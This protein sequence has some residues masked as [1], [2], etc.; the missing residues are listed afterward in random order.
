MRTSSIRCTS[1]ARLLAFG[2]GL[3]CQTGLGV[4]AGHHAAADIPMA[5]NEQAVAVAAGQYSG[6]V[7]TKSGKA[8]VWGSNKR[9]GLAAG[10]SISTVDQLR[11]FACGNVGSNKTETLQQ[12]HLGHEHS[13]AITPGGALFM[14]GSAGEGQLGLGGAMGREGSYHG[15]QQ[16][17]AVHTPRLIEEPFGELSE[18]VCAVGLSRFFSLFLCRSGRLYASGSDFQF[19]MGVGPPYCTSPCLV[20]G[21]PDH[22][23]DPVVRIAAGLSFSLAITA[24]GRVF[25]WG[26]LG[27]GGAPGVIAGH[28]SHKGGQEARGSMLRSKDPMELQLPGWSDEKSVSDDI[29]K[30]VYTPGCGLH[31]TPIPR[32][33]HGG[34]RGYGLQVAAG[35]HHAAITDGTHL[36][37]LGIDKYGATGTLG[38]VEST[39]PVQG[40]AH[41]PLLVPLPG[42]RMDRI[43]AL[44]CGP[45][46]TAI[47]RNGVLWTCGRLESP[48]LLGDV[49]SSYAARAM[50]LQHAQGEA[51]EKVDYSALPPS[52][53]EA[54]RMASSDPVVLGKSVVSTQEALLRSFGI[55]TG[56]TGPLLAGVPGLTAAANGSPFMIAPRFVPVLEPEL[57]HEGRK[58]ISMALGAAHAVA[59]C[60]LE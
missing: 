57:Y 42:D 36:W 18:K 38:P 33:T 46:T 32:P 4:P 26:S 21:L 22:Q 9:G 10:K 48:Y 6:G 17:E 31:S 14:V 16:A 29:S 43:T 47:V 8:Y 58:P 53:Q 49:L 56:Q 51:H 34:Q 40:T 24:S 54:I 28:A 59:I 11:L 15:G 55:R 13:A 7:L 30:T 25:F 50:G 60:A 19:A 2:R 5:E 52:L 44:A 45:Y 12:L 39:S 1:A 20:L 27:H 23:Q 35:L 3:E 37:T 41:G